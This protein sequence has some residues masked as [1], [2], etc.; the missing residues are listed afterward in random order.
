MF[1]NTPNE[2]KKGMRP[3][4]AIAS[5]VL[6]ITGIETAE[7]ISGI[8]DCINPEL[9]IIV[10]SLA[11]RSVERIATTIQI[12]DTGIS[13]GS[14]IGN[15]R[16]GINLET[17]GVPVI[18]IGIPTVV[19]AALI[20]ADAIEKFLKKSK[21]EVQENNTQHIQSILLDELLAPFGGNL[22]VTTKE[23]DM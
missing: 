5:V 9:I 23:I 8:V 17:I 19:H 6:G 11:S 10:D 22:M 13:P 3:V 4:S 12:A 15:H 1:N 16:A 21:C 7:I 14:G 2:I 20:A 18:A